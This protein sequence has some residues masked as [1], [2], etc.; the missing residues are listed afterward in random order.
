MSYGKL[1]PEVKKVWINALLSGEYRQGQNRLRIG[2]RFCCLGVLCDLSMAKEWC[3]GSYGTDY[4]TAP[5]VV[6]DWADLDAQA[7]ERLIW[8]N[9]HGKSFA[10][11]AAW[12]EEHL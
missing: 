4:T 12:I 6:R 11:I 3:G 9:D 2:D 10:E 5:Q 8:M 7:Q 1:D